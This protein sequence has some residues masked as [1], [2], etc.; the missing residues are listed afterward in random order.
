MAWNPLNDT[1]IQVGKPVKRTLWQKIKDSLEYLYGQ[2]APSGAD[3]GVPNGSFEVDSDS[4][5]IPDRWTRTLYAGG[6]GS[7]ETGSPAHG[8]K[9]WKFV[10]PGGVGNGGGYLDS[11]YIE[12]SQL[13]TYVLGYTTWAS[14]AGMRNLVQLLYYNT[15]KVYLSTTTLYDSQANPA[16]PTTYLSQYTPPA[17]SRFIKIRLIGG[18][19]D[20]NVA[21][22]AYFDDIKNQE[23]VATAHM[24]NSSVT[25]AKIAD[26]N[27]TTAKIADDNVTNAKMRK[28]FSESNSGYISSGAYWYPTAGYYSWFYP[29][30]TGWEYEVYVS[31]AGTWKYGVACDAFAAQLFG[32]M[33]D[34][35]NYRFH[36]T[37]ISS[38]IIRYRKLD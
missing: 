23:A 2:L 38:Q 11:D 7:F 34:G 29:E 19:S 35:S 21:G 9:A 26:S 14:A 3:S 33:V 15:S 4:D 32:S 6:S 20:V 8:A 18:N 1:E 22:T 30:G 16:T 17:N 10:H 28:T 36:N 37:N 25:T 24:L 13:K 12:I 27:V 31:G 5:G